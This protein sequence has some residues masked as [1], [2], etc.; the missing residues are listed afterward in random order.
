M[1]VDMRVGQVESKL[2]K[3]EDHLTD[4]LVGLEKLKTNFE[5][6]NDYTHSKIHYL[7]NSDIA[8]EHIL[9]DIKERMM[10]VEEFIKNER[11]TKE[12]FK[13]SF[14]V[15]LERIIF[16]SLIAGGGALILFAMEKIFK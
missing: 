3:I 14:I 5:H 12:T 6:L 10:L 1:S 7:L 16:T 15:V 13:K 4:I 9:E 11:L 2:E 8:F